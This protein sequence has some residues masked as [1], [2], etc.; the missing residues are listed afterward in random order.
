MTR[1]SYIFLRVLLVATFPAHAAGL[2][3][4]GQDNCYNDSI[5]DNVVSS[6]PTSIAR[7][8]GTHP[9]QDCRHGRDS[10]ATAG[11]LTKTGA[12]A[13]GFDY[14]KIANNGATVAAGIALG[15][16]S[17]DWACT[18]DNITDLTWEAKTAI[19][20]DLRYFGHTYSWYNSI[21]ATNGGNAGS[22]GTNSCNTTLPSSLCNTEAFVAAVNAAALCTYTDWRMPTLRE[23]LTLVYADGSDP[24]IEPTY[25]PNTPSAN[26]WSGSSYVPNPPFAWYV[27]FF[28]GDSGATDNAF[29]KTYNM[30]Y[31][32]LV[33]GGQF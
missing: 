17:T 1:L 30:Y 18:K 15:T 7:D 13:K 4:T 23:L 22:M 33:R 5:A 27:R 8:A 2:P 14:T 10:A 3:D 29:D 12:G 11:V 24:S 20:T 28:D 32:R 25:F 21:G 6:A 19:N 9:R 26:F 16:N 31:V